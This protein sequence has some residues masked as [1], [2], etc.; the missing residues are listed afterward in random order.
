MN[1]AVF[2]LWLFV[3]ALAVGIAYITF[4]YL[5]E[6][7]RNQSSLNQNSITWQEHQAKLNKEI[8]RIKQDYQYKNQQEKALLKK[9]FEILFI[10]KQQ[11]IEQSAY[12][13]ALEQF[14]L[15]K[16]Q[17]EEEIDKKYKLKFEKW[18]AESESYFL[19]KQ[20]EI[21][22]SA[23][24]TIKELIQEERQ[25][26]TKEFEKFYKLE[27]DRWVSER[28]KE[29][30]AKQ[31]ELKTA[32]E[33]YAA[34]SFQSRYQDLEKE[35][36]A[37]YQLKL[38]EWTQNAEKEIRTSSLNASRNTIKG[39]VSEQI[40]PMLPGLMYEPSEMRFL[41]SPIDYIIFDGYNDAKNGQ[42]E[43]RAIV[44]AD[45]KRG[46]KAKLSPIQKKIKEAI[47]KGNIRW[48]T[49]HLGEDLSISFSS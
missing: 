25:R 8:E 44:L 22:S 27:F 1:V 3:F 11:D 5:K 7:K 29:L 31:Q 38:R 33:N 41:G 42:G 32:A 10:T 30:I 21:Q 19:R 45:V 23:D 46:N 39:K 26:L 6:E 15:E 9:D 37:Q 43:I 48:E 28:E 17:L 24:T 20:N 35:I 34:E 4:I 16:T 18:I 13:S 12:L 2:F 47:E 36:Q 49:I 14:N 40:L